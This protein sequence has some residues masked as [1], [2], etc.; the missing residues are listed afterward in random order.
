M[1]GIRIVDLSNVFSGPMA[2]ALLAD[3]GASV[4][5]V[6]SP[7]GDTGRRVGPAKGDLSAAFI[8]ANRG[9]RSI[10][11]D[12][13]RP[14]AR[15]ILAHLVRKAD[16]LVS[17]FRPGVLGRLGLGPAQLL[18]LNPTLVQLTI[19]GFGPDG[20]RAEDRAYDAV[21]QAVSGVSA[22]HR[23][24]HSGQPALLAT[25]LCDKLTALTAAQAVT[26]ALFARSRDAKGRH[27]EVSM[28]DA[29][30]AFQ[31][32]DA[33]YNH[34]F[35]DSPPQGFPEMGI[36]LKPYATADGMIAVMAPQQSEFAA[37]CRVLGRPDI[38][39]DERFA[40]LQTR[41]RHAGEL[42]ALLE[43]LMAL[44]QT[45]ALEAASRTEG[46]PVGRINERADVLTDPQVV[47]NKTLIELDHGDV[48]RVRLARAAAVFDGVALEPASPA[49]HLGEHGRA[50]L[51]E[52]GFDDAQI[53]RWVAS[54]L[55]RLPTR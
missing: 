10:A 51:G 50:V 23:D 40:S 47:H 35:L 31:W 27:V 55:L 36:T 45:S 25:T 11:L 49:P 42:R 44:Q 24:K 34:V 54:G 20:P 18:G 9:K 8:T 33:M 4:I 28:L 14:E 39:Q 43:P 12:L 53:S 2:T 41:S 32:V 30:L 19:T 21:I 6:E 3:Q 13:K 48:G 52:F 46:A 26:A 1:A 16:V 37:L 29:T 22:S 5:K 38:A 15:E 7:E 17:N